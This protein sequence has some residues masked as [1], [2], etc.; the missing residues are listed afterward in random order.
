MLFLK[1]DTANTVVLTLTENIS[2]TSVTPSYLFQFINDDTNAEKLFTV[3]DSSTNICRYNQFVI[4]VTGGTEDLTGGTI[5]ITTNGYWKY[6]IYEQVSP[7]NIDLTG[8]TSIVETGK[9]LLS[10]TTL[11]VMSEYTGQTNTKIVYEG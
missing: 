2:I 9:M 7:T 10:G 5:D 3:S 6:N 1:R 11:P 8:T 4:T